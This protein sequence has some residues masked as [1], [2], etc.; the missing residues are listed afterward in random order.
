MKNKKIANIVFYKYYNYKGEEERKACVFYNDGTADNVSYE[1]GIDACQEIVKERHIT[2][3]EAFKELINND[4]IHV[5]SGNNFK[6]NFNNY[7][8]K[9]DYDDTLNNENIES[10]DLDLEE[11]LD[12][13]DL[14]STSFYDDFDD[15]DEEEIEDED[16]LD[17]DDFEDYSDEELNR[18]N[19]FDNSSDGEEIEDEE[20]I[21]DFDDFDSFDDEDELED[22]DLLDEDDFEEYDDYEDEADDSIDEDIE[23]LDDIEEE[24]LDEAK[25]QKKGI[26]GLLQRGIEKVKKS[27]LVRSIVLC[28]SAVVLFF[29][30][31]TLGSKQS[32]T[33]KMLNSNIT[34]ES[35]NNNVSNNNN[36]AKINSGEEANTLV[37]GNNDLYDDYSFSELQKVTTNK[38]QKNSMKALNKAITNYNGSFASAHIEKGKDV[39]AALT[40]DELV[41]LQHAYNDYSS[42]GI[43]AYF[44]GAEMNASKMENDYKSATLQLMGAHVI[45]TRKNP[46][47]MSNIIKGET[48]KEF[49]EKYHEMFLDAKE[50]TGKEKI[51]KVNAFRKAIREDFPITKE[52]RT[53]G[54]MH[55]DDYASI[56]SYKLS[57][58]P[59]IAAS[60][61]MFQ[62]LETDYTLNDLEIDF[63]N[64]IGLCNYAQDKFEKIEV[65]TLSAEEDNTNPLYEQY[66]NASIK[67]L[68]DKG[69]YVTDDKHRDLSRLDAF[70]DQVNWHFEMDENGR[71]TG[72]VYYTTEVQTKTKQ[73]KT[74]KV[75]RGEKITRTEKE[76]PE[77]ERRKIDKEIEK[78]NEKAKAEGEK[79]AAET[80]EEMQKDADKEAD[81][82]NKDIEDEEK[83]LEDKIDDS[84]DQIDDNNKDQDES[85]DKA[86]N[87]G[88]FGNH[89]V[90][91]DDKHSDENGNLDNS[92]EDI[93]TDGSGDKTGEDLPDPEATGKDFD[94]KGE[95]SQK[96]S[97]SK[98]TNNNQKSENN[99]TQPTTK[100]TAGQT[101]VEYEEPVKKSNDQLVDDYV[102]KLANQSE[103]SDENAKELTK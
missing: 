18:I 97:S 84:N 35:T 17:E 10:E 7:V 99:S 4:V 53:E 72:Q 8:V 13:D 47:D 58:V 96:S 1:E 74:K 46:V 88:D 93:T 11:N 65:I 30:G 60:E 91:F 103:N 23:D 33:G 25:G 26:L 34:T 78:E 79:E 28:A 16:L 5:M 101:I 73:W 63:L 57:V 27:K 43:K 61:M 71:Y 55:A 85:N 92:V 3:K 15:V 81:Q 48:A 82:I 87:E 64:D 62:N 75:T 59:M 22:D 38:T 19:A 69:Q 49:Y 56:E 100:S 67:A 14:D 2:S 40:F 77:S 12:E 29:T 50:A 37:E 39:R 21:D 51:E 86:V 44:N 94:K 32:K 24:S 76:I 31:Y 80:Q 42:K 20:D 45:E 68:K 66:R 54:I 98:N 95:D 70:Q 6:R 52:V 41:A 83:D 102:E 36:T 90:D 9:E 89:D